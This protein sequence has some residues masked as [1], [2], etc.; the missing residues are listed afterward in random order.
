MDD[1]LEGKVEEARGRTKEGVGRAID[2]P[3]MEGEGAWDRTKGDVRQKIGD[4]KEEID[5]KT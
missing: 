5:E 1:K 4:V 3:Q 2:D